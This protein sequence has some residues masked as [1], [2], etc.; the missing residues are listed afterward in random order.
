MR[1]N[2]QARPA[3]TQRDL[4]RAFLRADFYAFVQKVF[5]T[6]VPGI[7]FS[8]NWSAEAV[9]HALLRGGCYD[10]VIVGHSGPGWEKV[11]VI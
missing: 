8:R 9:T 6:V 5:E 1:S 2:A 4:L 10:K 3:Y 11:G 7:A